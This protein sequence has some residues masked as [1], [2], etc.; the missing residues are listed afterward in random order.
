[1]AKPFEFER[2]KSFEELI[3]NAR[4]SFEES[5]N[6]AINLRD[7]VAKSTLDGVFDEE[8]NRKREECQRAEESAYGALEAL[9]SY[10]PAEVSWDRDVVKIKEPISRRVRLVIEQ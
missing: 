6:K 8:V 5:V 4:S 10:I 3:E 1:M 2:E 7:E 9:L